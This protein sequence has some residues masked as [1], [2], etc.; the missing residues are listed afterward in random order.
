MDNFPVIMTTAQMISD[1]ENRLRF[2]LDH[3]KLLPKEEQQDEERIKDIS[4]V[5]G[6]YLETRAPDFSEEAATELMHTIPVPGNKR[7][8]FSA[9]L[10]FAKTYLSRFTYSQID[11]FITVDIYDY[12]KISAAEGK[13]I[14]TKMKS[15][16][17]ENRQVKS[18]SNF[19]ATPKDEK[20]FPQNVNSE[21]EDDWESYVLPNADKGE[22]SINSNGIFRTETVMSPDG[23][24]SEKLITVCRTP[25]VLCGVSKSLTG[26]ESYYKIR[27]SDNYGNI[28][29]YWSS[30]SVL[31]SK[32]DLK[33]E[34][35]L[36]NINCPESGNILNETVDYVSNSIR[37]MAQFF[38]KEFS[39]K[40][41][42]W[43]EDKTMFVLGNR[44]V[45]KD[46][47]APMLN[48]GDST[49]FE[50]LEQRGTLEGWVKGTRGIFNHEIIRFRAYDTMSA[51]TNYV[52][53]LESHVTDM[54]GN[55]SVGKTFSTQV[56]LTMAGRMDKLTL[57]PKSTR[58]GMFV[59]VRDYSDLPF[60]IDETTGEED[61]IKDV[62]YQI[63]GGIA[64]M[65]STQDGHRDGGEIY[66]TT[67]MTTGENMLRDSLD[68]A[69]QMYR[70]IELKADI[71]VMKTR[72]VELIKKETSENCGHVVDLFL[73]KVF[74][75]KNNKTLCAMY[76]TC[77]GELPEA[78][79]N[80][81]GRSKS[82]FAGIMVAG[83]I[84]EEVF[85]EIGIDAMDAKEIV[86]KYFVLCVKER[87]VEMEWVRALRLVNDW[88]N[89][90][91]RN[92]AICP[93][94]GTVTNEGNKRCGYI[95]EKYIDIVGSALTL[96][97]KENGMKPTKIKEDWI[98]NNV[99][100]PK[101]KRGNLSFKRNGSAVGGVRIYI[102]KM[103]DV[104]G[105]DFKEGGIEDTPQTES[106]KK[107]MKTVRFLTEMQGSASV[108]LI[109]QIIND[110]SEEIDSTL[111]MLAKNGDIE[112][113]NSTTFK[114]V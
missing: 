114:I 2:M 56:C 36:K 94:S 74:E 1:S 22:Y 9:A 95:D 42:G 67:C 29:E 8:K 58:N 81:Q 90:E 55:T 107:V 99:I 113:L 3:N 40:Q 110:T 51:M 68:N 98:A 60:L 73:A 34:F 88:V 41:C 62:V 80:V 50:A 92:F 30:P 78:V 70:V 33:K 85:A 28:Q 53:G 66:R 76:E 37:D 38:K 4:E 31:M 91:Y 65:K 103:N 27:Y 111:C 87:P 10:D 57:S 48:I 11:A 82:I 24:E 109:K 39:A 32:Q 5:M 72:E 52:I 26:D 79:D 101:D 77:L 13:L 23:D 49:G 25:F 64:K 83:K 19:S 93:A 89:I 47:T 97:L 75:K 96:K 16:C 112:K 15:I 21:P 18:K 35:L 44:V 59:T 46:G 71:P 12:F 43:T 100:A 63:T 84:L 106:V 7:D 20:E 61:K 6:E 102:S 86:N 105:L 69:G 17:S 104:L 54:Y 108:D 14:S 45:T